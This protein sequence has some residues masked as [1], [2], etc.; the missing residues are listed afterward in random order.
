MERTIIELPAL[1]EDQYRELARRI[2]GIVEISRGGERS[3][4]S[5]EQSIGSPITLT[6]ERPNS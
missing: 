2:R 3:P 5:D 1:S 6:I 4:I